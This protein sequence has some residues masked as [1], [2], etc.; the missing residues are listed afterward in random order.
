MADFS[1]QRHFRQ[2]PIQLP[3]LL[4]QK[5]PKV[6]T[7]QVGWT[8]N[9][10]HGGAC[11][12]LPERLPPRT[13]L[14]VL[15][16]REQGT[17]EVEAKV[18]WV[19]KPRPGDGGGVP[20]GLTFTLIPPDQRQAFLILLVSAGLVRPAGLRLPCEVPI[21]CQSKR[22]DGPPFQ[23]WTRDISRGGLMLRL[24]RVLPPE[25]A[26]GLT[27]QTPQGLLTAEGSTVWVAPPEARTPGGPVR[28]GLRFTNVGW[29]TTL[30]LARLLADLP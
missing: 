26:L 13:S 16:R 9:L 2:Y 21:T 23:G 19:G 28:H 15:L 29:S 27:L 10:G 11:V 7:H 30:S 6:S 17:L 14:R 24:P 12:D 25:T 18:A 20:H 4:Q 5:P 3:F 1:V 22:E 8:R